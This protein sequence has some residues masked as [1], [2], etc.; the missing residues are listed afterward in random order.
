MNYIIWGGGGGSR[1]TYTV[2]ILEFIS[3]EIFLFS[4]S[5][6]TGELSFVSCE[7]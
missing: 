1:D 6:I 2:N 7:N 3:F 4:K 5:L